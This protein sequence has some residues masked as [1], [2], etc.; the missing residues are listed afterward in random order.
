MGNGG[1][2]AW[3]HLTGRG[4]GL[5]P[6]AVAG[7][8]RPPHTRSTTPV[9][10]NYT[11]GGPCRGCTA[12]TPAVPGPAPPPCGS[13]APFPGEGVLGSRTLCS[14]LSGQGQGVTSPGT[15]T[16]PHVGPGDG[17]WGRAGQAALDEHRSLQSQRSPP[18]GSESAGPEQRRCLGR[19]PTGRKRAATP[20]T[21]RS[22]PGPPTSADLV[23]RAG[24]LAP[25]SRPRLHGAPLP[26][27]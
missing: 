20:A 13:C 5:K 19:A 4:S 11:L 18:S 24:A 17:P 12:P 3:G 14:G 9:M 27:L 25:S 1:L 6:R 15:L 23:P 26:L 10:A 2:E 16:A 7:Q 21:P 8:P 22:G